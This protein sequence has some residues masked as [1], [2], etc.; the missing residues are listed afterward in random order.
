MASTPTEFLKLATSLIPKFDVKI[1]IKTKIKRHAR[2]LIENE[3]YGQGRI[4]R[5]HF[6][7]IIKSPTKTK[8]S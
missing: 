7:K 5:C 6:V 3:K 1:K 4:R 2:D 8:N